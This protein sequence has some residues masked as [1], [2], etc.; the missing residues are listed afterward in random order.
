MRDYQQEGQLGQELFMT[1][2]IDK[3][4]RIFHHC[5]DILTPTGSLWVNIGDCFNNHKK[6]NTNGLNKDNRVRQRE[7]INEQ[8]IVKF[9]QPGIMRKSLLMIPERFAIAMID[10]GWGLRNR[11]IWHKPDGMPN[12]AKDRYTPDYEYLYHFVKQPK[13][14]YFDTQFEPYKTDV[15]QLERYIREDYVG[16]STRDY[17]GAMAQNPSNSKRRIIDSMRRR[18]KNIQPRFGGNK[19]IS[20][21]YGNA[22]YSGTPWAPQTYGRIKRSVWTIRTAKSEYA[23]FATFPERLVESPLNA[24][25]PPTEGIVL[26]PFM[27]SGTVGVVALKQ[28]KRFIGIELSRDYIDI[29]YKRLE[30]FL[31]NV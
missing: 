13:G 7:G 18:H 30:P 31:N 1:D 11:V 17:E 4:L 21:G 10:R 23:H 20:G 5:K 25:C 24:T 28:G 27:G 8:K 19:Q 22:I 12:S 14:Y 26:D 9:I 3:L 29:A 15:R 2:Y 6:G 16:I